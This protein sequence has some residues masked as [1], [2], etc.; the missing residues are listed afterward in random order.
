MTQEVSPD[1]TEHSYLGR[2]ESVYVYGKAKRTINFT[3]KVMATSKVE[4]SVIYEKL[5]YLTSLAYPRYHS[6]DAF[7]NRM[8]PPLCSLRIGELFGNDTKN[9]FF[10]TNF[11]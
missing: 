8:M 9:E 4:V 1:W 11:S 3:F 7:K 10:G 6:D 5:N 2:S